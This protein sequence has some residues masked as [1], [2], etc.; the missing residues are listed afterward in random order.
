MVPGEGTQSN[1]FS[2]LAEEFESKGKALFED[3]SAVTHLKQIEEFC[4]IMADWEEYLTHHLAEDEKRLD[5][6]HE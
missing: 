3:D 6:S 1:T 5:L 2:R 4:D